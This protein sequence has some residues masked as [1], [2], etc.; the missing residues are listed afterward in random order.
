LFCYSVIWKGG[1]FMERPLKVKKDLRLSPIDR[2]TL[3]A[4]SGM[5]YEAAARPSTE[6]TT[7][8]RIF[9]L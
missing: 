9:K 7:K 1:C 8:K 3:L 6:A 2:K 5:L 4:Y